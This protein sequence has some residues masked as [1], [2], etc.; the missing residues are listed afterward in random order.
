MI[1]VEVDNRSGIAVD[2]AGAVELSRRVLAGEGVDSGE[3]G[4]VF[5]EPDESR[6]LKLEHLDIDE[7][8]DALAFPMD[9]L[10]P[11]PDGM[12]RQLG[13]VVMC[14]QV[15]GEEWRAPLVHAVLHLVGYDHGDAM[16]AREEL[17]R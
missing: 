16:D 7:A 6:A 5:V 3:L 15:V 9:G 17:Y 4:L 12:P 8:T 14:P 13:D 10:D 1:E 11:V 2:E